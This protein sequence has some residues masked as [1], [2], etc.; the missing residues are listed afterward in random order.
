ML[1]RSIPGIVYV[2]NQCVPFSAD[3]YL[4]PGVHTFNAYPFT[5]QVFQGWY[6][7]SNLL[8]LPSSMALTPGYDMSIQA[9]FQPAKRVRFRTDPPGLKVIF[10]GSEIT[11]P[12]T[13]FG[14]CTQQQQ[15]TLSITPPTAIP[16]CPAEYDVVQGSKHQVNVTSQQLDSFFRRRVFSK[17]SNGMKPGDYWV[18]NSATNYAE[19]ITA[20]F[21]FGVGYTIFSTPGNAPF[22][23]D[24]RANPLTTNVVWGVGE[25]HHIKAPLTYTDSSNRVWK[26][27]KWSN[28]GQA[29]QDID[30][31]STRLNSSH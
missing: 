19:D 21:T 20:V 30:R 1:F 15:G 4:V 24:G 16:L 6:S 3:L 10:D 29:E 12:T 18:A 9:N 17:F 23:I 5:G 11:T 31:K 27:V 14:V 2:D 26:F 28:G 22:E 13:A 7:N 8:N 25:T